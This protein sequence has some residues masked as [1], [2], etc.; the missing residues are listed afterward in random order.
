MKGASDESS[1]S[2]VLQKK[3]DQDKWQT[4]KKRSMQ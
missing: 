4:M 2:L 1:L 3:M